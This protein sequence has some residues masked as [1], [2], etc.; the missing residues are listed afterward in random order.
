[1]IKQL[2]QCRETAEHTGWY[3]CDLI[4]VQIAANIQGCH[5]LAKS[6]GIFQTAA[7]VLW[8][9]WTNHLTMT[10]SDSR[11]NCCDDNIVYKEAELSNSKKAVSIENDHHTNYFSTELRLPAKAGI[12]LEQGGNA[13]EFEAQYNVPLLN[14]HPIA[15]RARASQPECN[16]NDEDTRNI[17]DWW[18]RSCN[19]YWIKS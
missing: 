15:L 18:P 3:W 11:S 13:N 5:S 1:M 7:W 19:S 14:V 12:L 10:W 16:V 17:W 4:C 2:L 8:D 6:N 9:R